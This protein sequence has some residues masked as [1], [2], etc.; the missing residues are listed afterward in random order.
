MN[1][2]RA[3]RCRRSCD[4]ARRPMAR[5]SARPRSSGA[6][7]PAVPDSESNDDSIIFTYPLD[8]VPTEPNTLRNHA[9]YLIRDQRTP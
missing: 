1:V 8:S 5:P 2:A 9:S 6:L 3:A 7:L 4:V